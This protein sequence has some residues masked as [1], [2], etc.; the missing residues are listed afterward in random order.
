M[1]LLLSCFFSF[2]FGVVNDLTGVGRWKKDKDM[3]VVDEEMINKEQEEEGFMVN[4]G[5]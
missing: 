3:V 4:G 2:V 1:L 5:G